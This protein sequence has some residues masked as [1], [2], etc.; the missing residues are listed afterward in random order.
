MNLKIDDVCVVINNRGGQKEYGYEIFDIVVVT[1]PL[2]EH[3]F[4][5]AGKED[6]YKC[7]WRQD[8]LVKAGEL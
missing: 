7:P 5:V 1:E 8:R 3:G 2:D 4:V 6:I